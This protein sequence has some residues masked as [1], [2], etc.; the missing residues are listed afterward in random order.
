M[1]IITPST[2]LPSGPRPA[3][4]EGAGA[5]SR[6]VAASRAGALVGLVCALASCASS[7]GQA[8]PIQAAGPYPVPPD[9]ARA[10]GVNQR[11]LRMAS[12]DAPSR[13]GGETPE[14][15]RIGPNDRIEVDVF[16]AAAFSGTYQVR[17]G[18]EIAMPLLGPIPAGGRTPEELEGL[19]EERL[20]ATYMRDPHVTVQIAEMHSHGVSVIGAVNRPGV[21][22]VPGSSTLL[23][24][25]AMAEGLTEAAG[26]RVFVIRSAADRPLAAEAASPGAEPGSGEVEEIDLGVLLDSGSAEENI[27][28]RPG[29]IV[30]VHPAGLVYVVGE[31]NRPGGFTVP[32]GEPMTVLQALA[33]AQGL[34]N[35][36]AADR[37]VIVRRAED[38]SRLEIPV[39]L[40]K[41]LKGSEE[42]PTLQAADVLFVPK[43]GSKSFALG[44]VDALV[45][46]VTF[47]G[48]VY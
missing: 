42:P 27:V 19:L 46:M 11:I 30:Q 29:D 14:G 7:E 9:T 6:L 37:S 21:Y 41:T 17:E 48:L 28:V 1:T 33:M 45:R 2:P 16:G 26:S 20:R 43:N 24:V 22:Q 13:P 32:P 36:A 15:Y 4:A 3:R 39:D 31:V 12:T 18:G 5:R 44:F 47:R 40:D 8:P 35:T 10:A 23:E 38:G 25:L 34:G